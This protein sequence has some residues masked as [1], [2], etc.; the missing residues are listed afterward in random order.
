M[1]EPHG[2]GIASH[3]GPESYATVREGRREALTGGST[4]RVL[5]SEI[6]KSGCRP[7]PLMGKA[8]RQ[9]AQDAS[10]QGGTVHGT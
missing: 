9:T 2:E 4:G 7:C 5:S 10:S 8:T 6:T 1:K 3:T